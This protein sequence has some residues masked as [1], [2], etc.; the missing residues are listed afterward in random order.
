MAWTAPFPP[1]I[2]RAPR[3]G[4]DASAGTHGPH[5]APGPDPFPEMMAVNAALPP[6]GAAPTGPDRGGMGSADGSEDDVGSARAAE[7][8]DPIFQGEERVD[9]PVKKATLLFQ[10]F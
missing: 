7:G 5:P 6:A 9:R 3:P 4:A 2:L 10:F 8:V 1:P